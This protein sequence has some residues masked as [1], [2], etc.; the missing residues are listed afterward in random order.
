[1]KK[2]NTLLINFIMLCAGGLF[3]CGCYTVVL[4]SSDDDSAL[5]SSN[6]GSSGNFS[7]ELYYNS[8]C[9]SCHSQAELDDRYYDLNH[10]GITVVHGTSMDPYGW[11]SPIE[12]VPWWAPDPQLPPPATSVVSA[13]SGNAPPA[14]NPTRRRTEGATRNDRRRED[15]GIATSS[16]APT[17]PVPPPA[18]S[19]TPAPTPPTPPPAT[20]RTRDSDNNTSNGNQPR[21]TTPA[22][23][24]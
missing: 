6:G 1:M 5:V 2:W 22:R 24:D 9:L 7:S 21:T 14:A 20:G 12:S 15:N 13:T 18:T 8:N 17:P 16:S 11:R 3:L 23:K 19:I 4:W 10:S